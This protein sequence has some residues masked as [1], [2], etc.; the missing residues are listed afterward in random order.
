MYYG[1][2]YVV[3]EWAPPAMLPGS[4]VCIRWMDVLGFWGTGVAMQNSRVWYR[5]RG[6]SCIC[7]VLWHIYRSQ[8]QHMQL[9]GA[10]LNAACAYST[11]CGGLCFV[12]LAASSGQH[13]SES[14]GGR[15]CPGWKTSRGSAEVL[16]GVLLV[17]IYL[18]QAERSAAV[19]GLN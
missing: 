8:A 19:C 5:N 18:F 1:S 6:C 13:Y 2:R 9:V 10:S 7:Y 16:V 15:M 12:S 11:A 17:E 4:V 14:M 3:L